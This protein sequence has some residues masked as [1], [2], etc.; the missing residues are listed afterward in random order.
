M[1]RLSPHFSGL[2]LRD[3]Q[4]VSGAGRLGWS[5]SRGSSLQQAGL[6]RNRRSQR[7]TG[8]GGVCVS[9]EAGHRIDQMEGGVSVLTVSVGGR[10][11]R[12]RRPGGFVH[13][14]VQRV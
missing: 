7:A 14:F 5:R 3:H 11:V 9:M 10:E 6:R 8:A 4:S 13:G 12:V 1:C 2:A